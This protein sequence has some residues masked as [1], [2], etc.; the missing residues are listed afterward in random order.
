MKRLLA[1]I[2]FLV[3]SF[4]SI[5]SI[6]LVSHYFLNQD[7]YA[8][9]LCEN[10][11]NKSLK[12]NGKCHLKKELAAIETPKNTTETPK[13]VSM[14]F[15]S[16]TYLLFGENIPKIYTN[17]LQEITFNHVTENIISRE[18]DSLFRPPIV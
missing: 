13:S 4:N 8:N 17:Q 10:K 18:T 7:Y 3:I 14:K 2:L 11:S 9:V 15:E 5:V 12:C 6:G 1:I 16:L